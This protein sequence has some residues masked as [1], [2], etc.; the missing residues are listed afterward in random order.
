LPSTLGYATFLGG[1][2]NE[3]AQAIAVDATGT[4]IY[5]AGATSSTDF[6]A[7]D[8]TFYNGGSADVFV[9]KY[10][11]T[12]T[13]SP[14][15]SLVWATYLGG[16]GEDWAYGIAVD[17]SG[18]VYVTGYTSST[19]F[20]NISSTPP[21]TVSGRDAFVAKYAPTPPGSPTPY[22]RAWATYLPGRGFDT[23][24]GIA[25]DSTG[26]VYAAGDD[27]P[28]TGRPRDAFVDKLGSGG[29]LVWATDL[30]GS[31]TDYAYGGIAVD[32]TGVYVAG[33]TNSSDFPTT[34]GAFDRVYNGGA[35]GFV[36]KLD[37]TGTNRLYATYLGGSNNDQIAGLAVDG[38]G[39][40]YVTG[41]TSSTNFPTTSNAFQR[42]TSSSGIQPDVFVA[43]L[44]ATG[45]ALVYSTYLGDKSSDTGAG[46]AVDSSGNIYVTGRT[47]SNHFPTRNAFDATLGGRTDG[48][49]AKFNPAA[50][51]NLSLLDSTYLGGRS[52]DSGYGIA[53]DGSGN[54][55]VAGTTTSSDFPVTNGSSLRG[56]DAFVAKLVNLGNPPS[57]A[58]LL[59][60]VHGPRSGGG[61]AIATST[62]GDEVPLLLEPTSAQRSVTP[63][64]VVPAS[65]PSDTGPTPGRS[66]RLRKL[67]PQFADQALADF[68]MLLVEE[69]VLAE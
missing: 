29:S 1:G 10:T 6:P 67:S 30:G 52:D 11:Y 3:I 22:Q 47:Y 63:A 64:P 43:E 38:S 40:V 48:F 56:Q 14:T 55:Y 54:A 37:L 50:S 15:Y 2:G 19:N 69:G 44:N 61:E 31:S 28:K 16:S 20:P 35:D 34:S 32:S 21:P 7:T 4:N 58:A 23:A 27:T 13:P 66:T 17:G 18:N 49:V 62:G 8:G 5:V 41:W 53:V 39:N 25:V 57:L 9:A 65:G 33:V 46:I 51:G 36:A 24:F 42:T 45:S 60:P 26:Y 59:V 12:S 68:E